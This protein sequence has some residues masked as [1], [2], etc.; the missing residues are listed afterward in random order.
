M[1]LP[2]LKHIDILIMKLPCLKHIDILMMKLPCLKHIDILIMKLPCLKLNN[3]KFCEKA[4]NIRETAELNA[5][6]LLNRTVG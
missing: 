4:N 1:R 6:L 3:T 5:V 2:C